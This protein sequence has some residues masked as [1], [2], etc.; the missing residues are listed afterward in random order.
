MEMDN[1]PEL[2]NT[3]IVGKIINVIGSEFELSFL[4]CE[5]SIGNI[6]PIDSMNIL[7]FKPTN[8]RIGLSDVKFQEY[9]E[10]IKL[11]DLPIDSVKSIQFNY[12]GKFIKVKLIK[13]ILTFVSKYKIFQE[14]KS[15]ENIIKKVDKIYNYLNLNN[16][17]NQVTREF[18]ELV[19]FYG[20]VD[21]TVF[22]F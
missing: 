15:Q 11:L 20:G 12:I 7:Y 21:K 6:P 9:I 16:P 5:D 4:P 17:N 13:N 2:T 14:F 3:Q 10:K 1:K 8:K 22:Y 18:I 19:E